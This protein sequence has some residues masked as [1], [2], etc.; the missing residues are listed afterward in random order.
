MDDDI[1]NV[2]EVECFEKSTHAPDLKELAKVS[3]LSYLKGKPTFQGEILDSKSLLTEENLKI[4]LR[5]KFDDVT[6]LFIHDNCLN[7]IE[8]DPIYSETTV[9][10]TVNYL[11][12]MIKELK[13]LQTP[14][15]FQPGLLLLYFK[16]CK[17]YEIPPT[18]LLS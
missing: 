17:G 11:L 1:D 15:E 9:P 3:V 10:W 2:R 14:K 18:P 13:R 16:L 6:F 8:P 12:G 7:Q 4:V 5:T